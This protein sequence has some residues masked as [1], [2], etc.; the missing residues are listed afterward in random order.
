MSDITPEPYLWY[1][2]RHAVEYNLSD[3]LESFTFFRNGEHCLCRLLFQ[4]WLH[5]CG[6]FLH[7]TLHPLRCIVF[8]LMRVFGQNCD[9][10]D[11]LLQRCG[12]T[13]LQQLRELARVLCKARV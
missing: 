10:V 5:C 4:H 2:G 8:T 3:I 9:G 12:M 7:Q 6:A 13:L 1:F 11:R